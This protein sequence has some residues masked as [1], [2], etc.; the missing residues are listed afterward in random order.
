M[1]DL[2]K[3]LANFSSQISP[4][5]NL[6]QGITF[7]IGM[8]L[9]AKSLV[10]IWGAVNDNA[11]KYLPGNK[12]FTVGGALIQLVVG[13]ML[14]AV[15]SLKMVGIL[16]RSLTGDYANSRFL[17]Y[18]P[19]GGTFEEERLAAMNALLGI[20]QIVGFIAIVK[21]WLTISSH[22][23]GQSRAGYGI[24]CGWLIGGVIAWNFKWFTD[25]LNCT[26]GYNI[27]G[28]FTTFGTASTC[29]M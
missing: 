28:M 22:A 24:A 2:M 20:M 17:S 10:E 18:A 12:K 16:S 23:N 29:G 11:L 26:L 7:C 5:L 4:I 15:A 27:I 3:I 21:G 25:V 19:A 9:V 13:S 6:L 1:P 8:Y 14:T